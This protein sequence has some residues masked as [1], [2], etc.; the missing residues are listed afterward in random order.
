MLQFYSAGRGGAAPMVVV[1]AG[2][3]VF[4]QHNQPTFGCGLGPPDRQIDI[5]L[6]VSAQKHLKCGVRRGAAAWSAYVVQPSV[7]GKRNLSTLPQGRMMRTHACC[8]CMSRST[9]SAARVRRTAREVKRA[10]TAAS[11][12]SG[13]MHFGSPVRTSLVRRGVKGVG[14]AYEGGSEVEGCAGTLGQ[15][16][17]DE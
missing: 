5:A 11:S 1:D 17:P 8:H 12:S 9:C 2:V 14:G 16:S 4:L 15:G 13:L 6:Q 7:Q 10:Q 3:N